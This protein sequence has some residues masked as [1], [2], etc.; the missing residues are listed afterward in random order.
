[1][2]K[3]GFTIERVDLPYFLMDNRCID[4]HLN[5]TAI[6][7]YAFIARHHGTTTTQ[8]AAWLNIPH[9]AVQIAIL[10]LEDAGILSREITE[11]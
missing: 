9:T 5:A 4:L 11:E 8:I 3:D 2:K 10:Q 6:A 1:M 7:V